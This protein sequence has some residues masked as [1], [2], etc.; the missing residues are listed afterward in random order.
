MTS[1]NQ[2]KTVFKLYACCISVMGKRRSVVYDLQRGNN[3]YFIPNILHEILTEH[4]NKTLAGICEIYGNEHRKQIEEYFQ[5][6][7]QN[8]LGFYCNNPENFPNL[9][10]TWKYANPIT[11]AIIEIED[12]EWIDCDRVLEQLDEV[13][14]VAL[15]LKLFSDFSV[16]LIESEFLQKTENN[17]LKSIELFIHYNEKINLEI[18]EYLCEKYRRLSMVIIHSC[19]EGVDLNKPIQGNWITPIF[20]IQES[21]RSDKENQLMRPEY[22]YVNLDVFTEAH[23]HHTYFNRKVVID[24]KGEIRN[25]PTI[26]KSFGNIAKMDLAEVIQQL[27]F[28]EL[29]HIRKDETRICKDCEFRYMCVDSRTPLWDEN[30]K[31]WYH[32]Q[33]CPYNPKTAFWADSV[34]VAQN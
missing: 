14:C 31:E 2:N 13:G 15:Q 16:D 21:L 26:K 23:H 22:F 10:R 7:I 8:E 32:K 12:L 30:K 17:R 27:D 25:C 9:D 29:W 20:S 19:P 24:S 34:L 4:E 18:I 3:Y 11:N 6:L 1:Y 28:Q 33:D 5:F